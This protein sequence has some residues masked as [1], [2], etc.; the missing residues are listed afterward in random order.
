MGASVEYISKRGMVALGIGAIV[1]VLL[2]IWG[3]VTMI[4]KFVVFHDP[5]DPLVKAGGLKP[6]QQPNKP[7]SVQ[8]SPVAQSEFRPRYTEIDPHTPS[9]RPHPC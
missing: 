2:T 9:K 5:S 1:L 8:Y 4:D 6:E 3:T 7:G